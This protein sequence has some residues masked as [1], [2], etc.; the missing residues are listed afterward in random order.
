MNDHVE[1]HS[2]NRYRVVTV[3]GLSYLFFQTISLSFMP[4]LTGLDKVFIERLED[5]GIIL[6]LLTLAI[7]TIDYFVMKRRAE[8]VQS[9]LKDDLVKDNM[10]RAAIFGYKM[11]FFV[12]TITFVCLQWFDMV[13]DD[14]AKIW[15]TSALVLPYLRFAYLEA[16]HA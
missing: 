14:V 6:F 2:R 12:G 7:G 8:A 16:K 10:K 4:E 15:V 3:L 1:N 9:A 11:L 13:A 5:I